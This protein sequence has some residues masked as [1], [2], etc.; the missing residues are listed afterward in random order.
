VLP[1]AP[2]TSF[3]LRRG[4]R[5]GR[6]VDDANGH[7]RGSRRDRHAGLHRVRSHRRAHGPARVPNIDVTA[8][9]HP[10]CSSLLE[11]HIRQH[12]FHACGAGARRGGNRRGRRAGAPY[13]RNSDRER[14]RARGVFY[15]RS[16]VF[17]LLRDG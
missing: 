10:D 16:S 3:A 14:G 11:I 5:N 9:T 17:P 6:H 12:D 4:R 8:C 15:G 13:D 2:L 1:S 7:R